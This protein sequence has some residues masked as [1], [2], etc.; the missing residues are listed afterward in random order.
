[1]QTVH[2]YTKK[3]LN[4]NNR[5]VTAY[6]LGLQFST[7]LL[8]QF[9]GAKR[10]HCTYTP[11]LEYLC[12]EWEFSSNATSLSLVSFDWWKFVKNKKRNPSM[13][14]IEKRWLRQ[15]VFPPNLRFRNNAA[16]EGKEKTGAG[17]RGQIKARTGLPELHRIRSP[18]RLTNTRNERRKRRFNSR[19]PIIM[20]LTYPAECGFLQ[21][22]GIL[23]VELLLIW[24]PFKSLVRSP[25][26]SQVCCA[27]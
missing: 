5:T 24:K 20:L 18:F 19:L 2:K 4:V 25:G 10:P 13:S 17:L 8:K 14:A 22:R 3:A 9:Y 23:A 15:I 21:W 26:T 12:E 16:A 27:L 1:M 6:H 11:N 7:N